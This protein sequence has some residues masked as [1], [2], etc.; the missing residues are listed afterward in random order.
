[1][2]PKEYAKAAGIVN[3][4]VSGFYRS[5]DAYGV[6]PQEFALALRL[7]QTMTV[8]KIAETIGVRYHYVG[9]TCSALGIVTAGAAKRRK[10]LDIAK[11]RRMQSIDMTAAEICKA[12]GISQSLL[13]SKMKA[14]ALAEVPKGEPPQSLGVDID[15]VHRTNKAE[16]YAE[17]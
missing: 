11:V 7:A 13:Y 1:M 5:E 12:L 2:T 9:I 4:P 6:S 17:P 15:A 10:E 3:G 16:A 8:K 14:A